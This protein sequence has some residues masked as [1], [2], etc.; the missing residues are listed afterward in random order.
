MD[1]LQEMPEAVSS[2]PLQSFVRDHNGP[3]AGMGGSYLSLP[4][5]SN[6][7]PH[8]LLACTKTLGNQLDI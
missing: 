1:S 3:S 2:A 7:C 4:L 5:V 8:L 6:P